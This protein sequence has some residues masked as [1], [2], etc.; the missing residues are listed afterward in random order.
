MRAFC[1]DHHD[2]LE[3]VAGAVWTDDEPSV[4]VLTGVFDRERMIYRVD[5][6][7]VRDTVLARRLAN[8]HLLIVLRKGRGHL[9]AARDL[10]DPEQKSPSSGPPGATMQQRGNSSWSALR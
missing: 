4:R 10:S 9:T 1:G 7:Q 6:V 8:L 5:D 2:H 3:Q